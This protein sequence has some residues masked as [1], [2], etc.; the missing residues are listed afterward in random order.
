MAPATILPAPTA[1]GEYLEK[2]QEIAV[3]NAKKYE[4]SYHSRKKL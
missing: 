2:T 3:R 1:H 4:Q